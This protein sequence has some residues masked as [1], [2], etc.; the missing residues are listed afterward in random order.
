MYPHKSCVVIT[1]SPSGVTSL[2]AVGIRLSTPVPWLFPCTKFKVVNDCAIPVIGMN[3]PS[4]CKKMPTG[5]WG[6]IFTHLMPNSSLE[7]KKL[8]CPGAP[9][10]S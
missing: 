10:L 9:E 7:R 6:T 4:S 8:F 2:F 5:S 3:V 1:A